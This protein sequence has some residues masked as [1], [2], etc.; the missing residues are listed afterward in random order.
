MCRHAWW[1]FQNH[2]VLRFCNCLHIC[3]RL[4]CLEGKSYWKMIW[5][6]MNRFLCLLSYHWKILLHRFVH[7]SKSCDL[8]HAFFLRSNCLRIRNHLLRRLQGHG[9][10]LNHYSL[11]WISHNR[12]EANF[13]LSK[14]P[15]HFYV[16]FDIVLSVKFQVLLCCLRS[17]FYWLATLYDKTSI[18]HFLH[19]P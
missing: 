10:D 13:S 17:V 1:M 14:I 5:L 3:L 18:L 11:W 16:E 2:A 6:T 12:R 15:H 7:Y 8:F 19:L 4:G 9:A